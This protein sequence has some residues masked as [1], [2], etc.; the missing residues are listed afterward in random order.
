M[1]GSGR[2]TG[3]RRS[4]KPMRQRRAA[5]RENPRGGRED[6]SYDPCQP[7]IRIPRKVIKGG[8]H[9]CAPNYCRRY[10]PAARHAEPV[11]TSTSHVG[12]R[13]VIREERAMALNKLI[14]K[15]AS[16]SRRNQIVARSSLGDVDPQRTDG[17]M[18]RSSRRKTEEG[19]RGSR[20]SSVSHERRR[21]PKSRSIAV[22]TLFAAALDAS[23]LC[24][25]A[26]HRHWPSSRA[27]AKPNILMII[28]R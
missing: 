6:A 8:S 10:R 13:C 21:K 2:R 27:A 17:R 3:S 26:R 1:S 16:C 19:S 15:S 22:G 28:W 20:N 11:D 25:V 7:S 14:H 18:R 23:G 5:F 9:L 24:P 12:F 4:T